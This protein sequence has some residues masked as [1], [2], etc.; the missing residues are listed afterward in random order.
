MRDFLH[1]FFAKV[2]I[3]ESVTKETGCRY[4]IQTYISRAGACRRQQGAY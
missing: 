2:S 1:S 4:E 3:I